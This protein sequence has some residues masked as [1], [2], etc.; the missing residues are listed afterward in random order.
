MFNLTEVTDVS[1]KENLYKLSLAALGVVFG[2]IGTSP[3]YAIRESIDKLPI[4]VADVLGILSLIFWA[5]VLVISIKYLVVVLRADNDGEGGVLALLALLTRSNGHTL[6]VFFLIGIFAAGLMLGDGM[7]TPAISVLS[8]IEGLEIIEP[9]LASWVLPITSIILLTLFAFQRLGTAKIGIAFGPIIFVWFFTLGVLGI[10]QIIQNPI[11]LNAINPYYAIEFLHATGWRG[12]GLLGG[13]FLVVTGGEALYADLGHFGRNPIKLSW[14][15]VALPGL[16]LNYFGQA[17]YLLNN[18]QAIV[19]PF[20]LIAPSWFLIPL[21]IIATAATIIASQAVISA[22]FSLTKQAILLGLYPILPI[23]QTSASMRGQIYVPQVNFILAVG[24]LF[25]IFHFKS[26]S[27]LAHAYGVAVNL[28]MLLTTLMIIYLAHKKWGWGFLRIIALFSIF[29]FIDIAFLGANI[30]KIPTGGWIPMIFAL[31]CAFIMFTWEKGMKYLRETY[32]TKKEEL[33]KV[34]K[35]LHYA[36]INKLPGLTAIFITD[37][38]DKSGGGFLHFLKLSRAMPENIL[39][40]NYK[41][42]KIPYVQS[43]NRFQIE[44]LNKDIFQLTLH[45]GFMDH[46]SIPQALYVASDRKIIPFILD[47]DAA[48]YFLE[49]PNIVASKKQR[50]LWFYWQEKL[51]S[52]LIRNYSVN[53]NIDFYQ[54]PYNHTIGIGGYWMI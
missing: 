54:L 4:T 2:D 33:S 28:V 3:L 32:F 43:N 19:N 45:Y 37:P 38:Y 16:L 49:I 20:Y 9:A 30:E 5:L 11:V 1:T 8:A 50:T 39:I 52:F 18:P 7:L 15:C 44:C 40:V 26:S 14:F 41:V 34:I 27:A 6:K 51:F 17:A 13:V 23:V 46:I 31:F 12:Y 35:Q 10:V 42:E 53:V 24:A 21:L 47:V 25:L 36:S 22:T 29:I 48:L